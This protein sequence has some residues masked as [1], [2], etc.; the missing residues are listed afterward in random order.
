MLRQPVASMLAMSR[1]GAAIRTPPQPVTQAGQGLGRHMV[2]EREGR[3]AWMRRMVDRDARLG[4]TYLE[5]RKVYDRVRL[6]L[7]EDRAQ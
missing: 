2:E 7:I 4:D 1:A 6:M 5:T 3:S